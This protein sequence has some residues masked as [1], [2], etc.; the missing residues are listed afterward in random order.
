MLFQQESNPTSSSSTDTTATPLRKPH[1]GSIPLSAPPD[2]RELM[3]QP[4]V[5]HLRPSTLLGYLISCAPPQLPSPFDTAAFTAGSTANFDITT[6]VDLLTDVHLSQQLLTQAQKEDAA[7]V[8]NLY[9]SSAEGDWREVVNEAQSWILMQR[10]LDTFFQRIH[11][12]DAAQ[13][14]AMRLWYETVLDIGSK[15]FSV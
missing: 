8:R 14:Q 5:S 3:K 12:A 6:Y 13:K 10:A 15:T 2:A 4:Y 11:V 7:S 1:G 9:V